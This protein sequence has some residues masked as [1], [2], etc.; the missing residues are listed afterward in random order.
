MFISFYASFVF[1][2]IATAAMALVY[3]KSCGTIASSAVWRLSV[4]LCDQCVELHEISST[5]A[6]KTSI[7]R[8]WVVE[9]VRAVSYAT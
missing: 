8:T 1:S 7:G 3:G 2:D 4:S 6:L 5:T 9:I